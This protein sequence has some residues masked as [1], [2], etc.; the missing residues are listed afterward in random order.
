[1]ER[2]KVE[3]K[4][5]LVGKD[6]FV[7]ETKTVDEFE[8][9]ESL[10]ILN[11]L[12]TDIMKRN[13]D[14]EKHTKYIKEK[15]YDKELEMMSKGIKDTQSFI[16]S[17]NEGIKPYVE[18]LFDKGKKRVEYYKHKEGYDRLPSD[19]KDKKMQI[20][21]VILNKTREDLKLSDMS[22]PVMM[23]LRYECFEEAKK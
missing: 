13:S 10:K 16:D 19:V 7:I 21:N 6:K 8:Q 23:K 18:G 15:Q 22:H 17:L 4:V 5:V 14:L 9:E 1:M 11:Q 20:K 2:K 12:S 3:R